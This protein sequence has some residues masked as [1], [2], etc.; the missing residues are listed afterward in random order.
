MSRITEIEW[1]NGRGLAMAITELFND[2]SKTGTEK[3]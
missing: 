2:N 3:D 1:N